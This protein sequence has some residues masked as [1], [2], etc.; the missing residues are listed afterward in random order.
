MSA[1]GQI[2][3]AVMAHFR[4]MRTGRRAAQLIKRPG[5]ARYALV[6]LVHDQPASLSA[7]RNRTVRPDQ[8]LAGHTEDFRRAPKAVYLPSA[9][10]V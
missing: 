4:R 10:I 8:Q 2:I 1:Q 3:D 5:S 6:A 7:A 9:S